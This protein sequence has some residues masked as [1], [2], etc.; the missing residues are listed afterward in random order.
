MSD[1]TTGNLSF[2]PLS[3]EWLFSLAE[4]EKEAYPEAWTVDEL[5]REMANP[6]GSFILMFHN[7]ELAGYA[8][9]WDMVDEAHITRVTVLP[10]FRKQG[11]ARPLME[12][13]IKEV[14]DQGL[15]Q[16]RLE[17]REHNYRAVLLYLM[18]GFRPVAYRMGYYR[19]TDENALEMVKVLDAS[20]VESFSNEANYND[21]T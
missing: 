8:G 11:L 19:R 13:L 21:H 3:F 6:R 2:Q 16:I 14:A 17:V 5:A 1:S 15:S 10:P 12:Q 18:L 9:F 4:A 7:R 20:S